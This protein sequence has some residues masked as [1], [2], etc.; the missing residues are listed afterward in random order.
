MTG[1][2]ASEQ[3]DIPV[4]SISGGMVVSDIGAGD[5]DYD[6]VDQEASS[7]TRDAILRLYDS[8]K[9]HG[10]IVR[11]MGWVGRKK[12]LQSLQIDQSDA[13]FQGACEVVHRRLMDGP[14]GEHL[15]RLGDQALEDVI[16]CLA[17]FGPVLW[18]VQ[19]EL[20]ERKKSASQATALRTGNDNDD[21]NGGDNDD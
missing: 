20:R 21:E 14:L 3:F 18:G 4:V 10:H 17:G 19:E 8:D 2:A 9:F 12:G 7:R 6:F 5:D 15:G 11:L 1:S 13:D 16:V